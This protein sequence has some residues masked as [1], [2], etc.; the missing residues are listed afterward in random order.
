MK[1]KVLSNVCKIPMCARS[2]ALGESE[3][4]RTNKF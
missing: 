3:F 4:L 2:S 1:Q